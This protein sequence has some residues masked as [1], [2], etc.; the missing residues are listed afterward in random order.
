MKIR[1]YTGKFQMTGVIILFFFIIISCKNLPEPGF[2]YTPTDNPEAGETIQFTNE[3]DNATSYGWDFGDGGA[4]AQENPSYIYNGAGIYGV[5]LSAFNKDGEESIIESVTIYEPTNLNFYIY[6][7][8][9]ST[10]LPNADVLIY[11]NT[12]DY[13]NLNDPQFA[14]MTDS[15]GFVVFVNMEPIVYYVIII[16]L[17][18]DGY[19]LAG[20]STDALEQ[21][22]DN[23]YE[24]ACSWF[25]NPLKTT[26][27]PIEG[28]SIIRSSHVNNI[29]QIQLR[30]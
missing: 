6:D 15:E 12:F 2:S 11:D 27:L 1:H 29:P 23:N 24:V 26:S 3:S 13:E 18:S 25:D 22:I 9:F 21:N 28:I 7:S 10:F 16:K 8:T 17:E 20:G 19:W 4:S 30:Q 5:K 14:E